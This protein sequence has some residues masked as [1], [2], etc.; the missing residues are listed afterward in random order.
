MS[1]FLSEG[2][3]DGYHGEFEQ[4]SNL[5]SIEKMRDYPLR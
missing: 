2:I 5:C 4:L 1:K 3:V